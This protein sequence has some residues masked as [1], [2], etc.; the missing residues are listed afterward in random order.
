WA[1]VTEMMSALSNCLRVV[2]VTNHVPDYWQNPNNALLEEA[3]RRY[4]KVVVA[5]WETV[6][7]HHPEWFYSDGTHMP[8]GGPGARAMA[9][10]IASKI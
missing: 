9:A 6:A 1:D 4:H 10:L 2:V 3:A 7:A 8:I 5:N